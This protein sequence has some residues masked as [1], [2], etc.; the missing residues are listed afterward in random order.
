[1]VLTGRKTEEDQVKFHMHDSAKKPLFFIIGIVFF[2]CSCSTAPIKPTSISSGDYE[3]TK[4]YVSWLIRK[5]MKKND[6]AGLSIALVDDQ[7][8]VW[9][10]GF[11]YADTANKVPATPETVYQVGSI[12]K[13]FTATAVMQLSEEGKIDIDQ[14]VQTDRCASRSV[15]SC[16]KIVF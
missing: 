15:T 1:M 13:L 7:R 9:A 16:M 3:Y 8:I 2:L 5:E 10:Q 11:G 12:S 6:V 4:Q 14:P